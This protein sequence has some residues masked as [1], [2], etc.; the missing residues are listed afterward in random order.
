MHLE[1]LE[2]VLLSAEEIETT[3]T[4][5]VKG[6]AITGKT[7]FTLRPEDYNFEIPKVVRNNIA[8]TVLVTAILDYK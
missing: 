5:T 6:G 3:G 7:E 2:T 1:K 4:I 8:E